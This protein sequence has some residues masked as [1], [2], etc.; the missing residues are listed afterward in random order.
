VIKEFL[1]LLRKLPSFKVDLTIGRKDQNNI[2][3]SRNAF[4]E[5]LA[6]LTK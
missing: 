2:S 1:L 3:V 6:R 5:V 4:N